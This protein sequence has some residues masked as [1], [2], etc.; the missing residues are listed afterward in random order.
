MSGEEI[1]VLLTDHDNQIGSLKHRMDQCEKQTEVLHKLAN[2]V[3]KLA[4]NMEYMSR[5]QERQGARLER[6]ER[7]PVDNHK[8]LKQTII[9][10]V[11]SGVV[12]MIISAIGAIILTGGAG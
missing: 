7:E 6:L 4:V 12:G 3:D 10:C 5:E 9:S 1:A 2:S 8:Y 11:V